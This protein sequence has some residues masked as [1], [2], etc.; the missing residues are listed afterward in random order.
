LT[1]SLVGSQQGLRGHSTGVVLSQVDHHRARRLLVIAPPRHVSSLNPFCFF[2]FGSLPL[3][4][5]FSLPLCRQLN[6]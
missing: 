4:L 1:L 2:L 5:R 3:L 6:N